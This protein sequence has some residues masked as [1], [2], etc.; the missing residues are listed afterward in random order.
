MYT[1]LLFEDHSTKANVVKEQDDDGDDIE[2]PFGPK[3]NRIEKVL[4]ITTE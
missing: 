3:A 2:K 1:L 4:F